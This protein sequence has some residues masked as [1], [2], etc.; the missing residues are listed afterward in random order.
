MKKKRTGLSP[1]A[2]EVYLTVASI[3][4][5]Q[6]RTYKWVAAKMG[7][8]LACR[9]VGTA[10]KNNPWPMLIPCHRVVKSGGDAGEYVYG[11]E[12]KKFLIEFERKTAKI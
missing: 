4:Y 8:E 3:P 6:V 11:R 12:M 1:F 2:L 5:G 10:L 7:K 9:A